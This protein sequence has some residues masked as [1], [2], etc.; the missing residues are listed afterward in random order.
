M[1]KH[2]LIILVDKR[3]KSA[4]NVQKILTEWG[5]LIKTR[6]GIHD[7]VLDNCSESGLIILELVGEEEKIKELERKLNLLSRVSAKLV[8]LDI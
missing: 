8:I 2:I 6:L 7:G 5:C 1:K 3:K 4:V